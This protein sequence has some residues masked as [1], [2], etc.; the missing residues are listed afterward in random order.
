[1]IDKRLGC[2]RA[3]VTRTSFNNLTIVPLKT[4][5]DEAVPRVKKVRG[6]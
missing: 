2:R 4:L 5:A 6:L 1:M 3:A